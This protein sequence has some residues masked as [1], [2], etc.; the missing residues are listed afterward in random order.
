MIIIGL[1]LCITVIS[2]L[3][4]MK[5]NKKKCTEAWTP[6]EID[7]YNEICMNRKAIEPPSWGSPTC[8]Y[9][10][11]LATNVCGVDIDKFCLDCKDKPAGYSIKCDTCK[12]IRK[13]PCP[14]SVWDE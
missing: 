2:I 5:V 12:G 6:E 7:K 10:P 1:L 8:K 13:R 9:A 14:P 3:V 11:Y 4:L